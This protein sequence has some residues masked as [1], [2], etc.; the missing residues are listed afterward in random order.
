LELA[1]GL[2]KSIFILGKQE[3]NNLNTFHHNYAE[4]EIS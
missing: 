2:L 1:G 4:K 3:L